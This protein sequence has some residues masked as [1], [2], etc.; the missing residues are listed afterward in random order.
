MISKSFAI[1]D[2]IKNSH[3]SWK[4]LKISTLTGVDSN[5]EKSSTIGKMLSNIIV[6]YREIFR[7]RNTQSM[8]Q[9]SLLIYLMN[10]HSH[11]TL[12]QPPVNSH[13][14][15]AKTLHQQKILRFTEDSDDHSH[16]FAMKY[17]LI[18]VYT[19]F[20]RHKA[21]IQLIDYSIVQP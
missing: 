20:F 16:F 19:L 7:E 4:G 8:Q 6:C 3:D 2:A 21:I 17:F 9:T 1:L 13:Q 11:P 18:K 10:C 14:H 5:F 12:Q 15:Q